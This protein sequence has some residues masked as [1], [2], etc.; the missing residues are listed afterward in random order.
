M[1]FPVGAS[2]LA[3]AGPDFL[4]SRDCAMLLRSRRRALE[5]SGQVGSG[6]NHGASTSVVGG[7]LPAKGN[8]HEAL[9]EE[10]G[11]QGVVSL[12][13]VL[14]HGSKRSATRFCLRNSACSAQ[15]YT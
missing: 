1:G 9:N 5:T 7:N 15:R 2:R 10:L 3:G 6:F 13:S 11:A 12:T 8:T 4:G 14:R